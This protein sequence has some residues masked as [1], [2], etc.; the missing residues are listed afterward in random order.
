M[1]VEHRAA[2]SPDDL[3]LELATDPLA[4]RITDAPPL[5]EPPSQ[6]SPAQRIE[7]A[8][9]TATAPLTVREL[10]AVCR[11]RSETLCATLDTLVAQGR[12]I[13]SIDGYSLAAA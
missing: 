8:L 11:I 1:S 3:T 7:Q 2:R 10:R 9:V 13:R 6:T 12:V 5:A 4:L